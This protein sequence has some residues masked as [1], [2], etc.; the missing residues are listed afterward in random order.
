MDKDTLEKLKA[1]LIA[2]H[3]KI[4][5]AES[6]TCGRLQAALGS[7]SGAS[8]FFEGGITTYNLDQKVSLLGIDRRYAESV[9]SVSQRIAFDLAAGVCKLFRCDIGI[10]TT[11]YAEA[12]PDNNISEP[13]AYFAICR[14]RQDKIEN[15]AGMQISGRGLN[16][17][18]MQEHV[19]SSALEA[20]LSHIE[21]S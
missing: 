10:G 15:I 9:N 5:V 20:L 14:Y 2:K 1:L 16:R 18:A 4:A 17:V 12:A 6:L 8:D 7:I 11:G 13:M 3:L 19:C 21:N